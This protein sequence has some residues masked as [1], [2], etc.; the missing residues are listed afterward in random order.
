MKS[1]R[2]STLFYIA[3]M[4]TEM[5]YLYLL[6]CLL[7]GDIYLLILMLFLYPFAFL[8]K[9][10]VIRPS[11]SHRLRFALQVVLVTM[12][13][14][15]VA[16]DRL[17]SSLAAGQADV[18]GIIVRMGFCGLVWLM[19]YTVP[20]AR[21][22]Y[23]IIAFRLQMGILAVLVFSQV[24]GS[25]PPVFLFFMLVPLALFL[26]RWAT[27]LSQGATALR[28][29]DFGHLILAGGSV[30][31]PG[32][33]LILLFSPR[34]ARAIVGWLGNISAKLSEWLM[35]RQE[36]AATPSD[37]FK[38]DFGCSM[39]PEQVVPSS[40][41][42]PLSPSEGVAT[43]SP[44]VIWIIVFAIFLLI[45]GVIAFALIRRRSRREIRP[46]EPM[47]FQ[48]RMIPLNMLHSL[49][50]FFLQ[51][52]KNVWRWL[53]SVLLRQR[54]GRPA[55]EPLVSIRAIYRHLLRWAAKRGV[56]RA[57]AQTPLEHL[58][59]LVEKFPEQQEELKQVIEAYLVARYSQRPA[60][61]EEF[62]KVRE[63][64]QRAT[65]QHT[66]LHVRG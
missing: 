1:N 47:Q 66:H 8:S 20:H 28:S 51:L 7:G 63:A 24:E 6:A 52:F 37:G 15:L 18:L 19:G 45:V 55:E 10:V 30:M 14:L 22:D 26:A 21:V 29:P 42:P 36:A 17:L 4:G 54:K 46:M 43:V 34:V 16:G 44:V 61:L 32:T 40:A 48:I 60:S 53:T 64:W 2:P 58:Q 35:A 25:A 38:F 13:I 27:S 9:L 56:D 33:A 5:T 39:R 12:V 3:F 31:V 57:P 65:E 49:I 62:S 50:C 59:L 23:S 41:P 11:F